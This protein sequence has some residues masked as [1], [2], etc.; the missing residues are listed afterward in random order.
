MTC[1]H[2]K[3]I[4]PHYSPEPV[5]DALAAHARGTRGGLKRIVDFAAG[6]GALLDALSRRFPEAEISASDA[7]ADAMRRLRKSHPDWICGTCDF[8]SLR[9]RAACRVSAPGAV[10]D[11]IA[12]N[13]PFSYRGQRGHLVRLDER[14]VRVSPAAA[15]VLVATSY[16][17][18]GEVLAI[19]PA[20]T[21]HSQ[22]DESAWAVI[23]EGWE[24]T[25]HDEFHRGAFPGL[26]ARSVLVSL[27]PRAQV[28]LVPVSRPLAPIGSRVPVRMIRGCTPRHRVR[29]DTTGVPFVHT[30]GLSR[31]G[32]TR[33]QVKPTTGR[34]VKGHAVLIPRV[35]NPVPW[36]VHAIFAEQET[37]LSDCVIAL[38]CASQ[39]DAE[40]IAYRLRANWSTVRSAW[41]GSCAPYTTLIRLA[42]TLGDQGVA[43]DVSVRNFQDLG[44]LA[45]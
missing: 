43:A 29:H 13:P 41:V 14:E 6:R 21:L 24:V 20:G 15:F 26:T 38:G 17:R 36:K 5:A 3:R 37:L 44:S 19:V 42:G 12:L 2:A 40:T 32:V 1:V 9:S 39:V 8:L 4:D 7:D 30:T 23:R 27:R 34:Y 16:A 45:A 22:K 28:D 18:A 31:S 10:Y 11:L 25:L 33:D 35:G